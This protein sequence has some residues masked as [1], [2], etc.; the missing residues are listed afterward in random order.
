MN[1]TVKKS[2]PQMDALHSITTTT[3]LRLRRAHW[4]GG[5]SSITVALSLTPAYAASFLVRAG[6]PRERV[7]CCHSTGA[8]YH[9]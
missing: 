8:A 5:R 7:S 4:V 1:L 6:N 9:F 3:T 2:E